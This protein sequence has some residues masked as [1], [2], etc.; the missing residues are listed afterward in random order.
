MGS[1]AYLHLGSLQLGY[2]NRELDPTALMLFSE[3]D[4]S[5]NRVL[6]PE[7]SEE[8]D[9]DSDQQDDNEINRYEPE[10]IWKVYYSAPLHV[11]KDRLQ[12]MGFSLEMTKSTFAEDLK[13]EI[14]DAKT[15]LNTPLYSENSFMRESLEL[16]L[17]VLETTTFEN[18]IEGIRFI[19]NNNF[20]PNIDYWLPRGELKPEIAALPMFIRYLLGS[21]HGHGSLWFPSYDSRMLLR[22]YSEI[23]DLNQDL[24]YDISELVND[25]YVDPDEDLCSWARRMTAEDH[26]I[27][28]K[29]IILTEGSTDAY[30]IST[31]IELLYPHLK[32]LYGFMDF[33]GS[34]A[35]G[36]ASALVTTLKAFAGAG[37]A[38]RIIAIFDNDTA[39]NVALKSLRDITLP[40]TIKI[41]Q[42][43]EIE[44][45]KS[46]PTLGPQGTQDID[47]NGMGVSIELFFGRDVLIG[48]DDLLTP[49][50]W[51][52]FDE[53]T[54]RYQGEI[55]RKQQLFSKFKNKAI[56][57]KSN[58]EIIS[59]QDWSS[60]ILL[61]DHIRAAFL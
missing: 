40:E 15:R 29:I 8:P 49:V 45:A 10:Y 32:D 20:E 58:P 36:G 19:I 42:H 9:T 50:Q 47:I 27:N 23:T 37:I 39:A 54:C 33:S 16:E 5:A 12:A 31:S 11:V 46:Y 51:K 4:K 28:S 43:P 18:W 35:P 41:L 26:I 14:E 53:S 56:L 1:R 52:G 17:S 57:A 22:A 7:Y 24:V 61:I 34:R 55:L 48:D 59:K 21:L 60:M 6:D 44:L 13:N 2:S 25:E 30:T 3:S 38:N